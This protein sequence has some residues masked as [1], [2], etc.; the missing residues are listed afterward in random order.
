MSTGQNIMVQ[1]G[2][3]QWNNQALHYACILARRD[4]GKVALVK[5]IPVQHVGWLGTEWGNLNLTADDRTELTDCVATVED[6]G[7][8]YT[9]HFFQYMTFGDALL[10]AAEFTKADVVFASLPRSRFPWWTQLRMDSLYRQFARQQR[11]LFDEVS[12]CDAVH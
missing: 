10:E 7:V 8:D 5:M 2:E 6:Y 11:V 3:H 1:V 4:A 12:L 9:T